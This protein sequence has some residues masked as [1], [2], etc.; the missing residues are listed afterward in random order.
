MHIAARI[1]V[2]IAAAVAGTATGL[3]L[4]S[5]GAARRAERQ[6]PAEGKYVQVKGARL[7]YLEM[8]SGPAIVM[9]H[10]LTGQLRN[11]T[12]AL[13]G[14][15]S[16]RYRIV[17]VDRPGSG[18]S[19]W[20]REGNHG[21]RAQA[22][23][24]ASF[25]EVLGLERPLLVG[26]SLGGAI[27]L[28]LALDRSELIGGLAL[29]A[30]LTQ[31]LSK[32]PRIFAPLMIASPVVRRLLASTLAIP[33]G[34][35]NR[36]KT[37]A[38]IFGP[39]AAPRDFAVRG[40]GLLAARPSAIHAASAELSTAV[41]ELEEMVPRYGDL[42]LPLGILFGEGDRILSPQDHGK[43]TAAMVPGAEFRLIEGGHMIPLTSAEIVADWISERAA[44]PA[45]T[46]SAVSPTDI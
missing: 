9:V 23:I 10:G 18:Y 36:R 16:G 40:G 22:A 4:F 42:V 6:V 25:I 34:A 33:L 12:Y 14:L 8:G 38:A 5:A 15:L 41:A 31:P 45:T 46:S 44:I 30:P 35:L 1:G 24:V 39:D 7:H 2:G 21:L 28:A 37:M 26:H 19:T 29:I 32:T 27:A 11:F 17:V 43:K 13:A 3:V 20:T